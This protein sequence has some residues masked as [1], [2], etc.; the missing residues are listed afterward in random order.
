MSTIYRL[1]EG[2]G[3]RIESVPNGMGRIEWTCW[4]PGACHSGSDKSREA[5]EETVAAVLEGWGVVPP[6]KVAV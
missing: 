1:S 5:A 3:A 4:R 2:T 6:A